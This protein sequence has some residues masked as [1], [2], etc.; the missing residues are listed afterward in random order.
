MCCMLIGSDGNV[1]SGLWGLWTLGP[2]VSEWLWSV[3]WSSTTTTTVSI[4]SHGLGGHVSWRS[5]RY[6]ESVIFLVSFCCCSCIAHT[7]MTTVSCFRMLAGTQSGQA[8]TTSTVSCSANTEQFLQLKLLGCRSPT[9]DRPF[10]Y[11]TAAN[12]VLCS[13]ETVPARCSLFYRAASHRFIRSQR[14]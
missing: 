7:L 13:A 11:A 12:S 6:C 2:A 8:L 1:E 14:S 9:V 3:T 4:R 10:A 5:P